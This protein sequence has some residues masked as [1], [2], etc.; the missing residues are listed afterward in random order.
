MTQTLNAQQAAA[1]LRR[2]ASAI[3]TV[4]LHRGG[5]MWP[6]GRTY[7]E[8]A[9]LSVDGALLAA[10]AAPHLLSACNYRDGDWSRVVDRRAVNAAD[11]ALAARSGVEPREVEA[12]LKNCRAATDVAA[13]LRGAAEDLERRQCSACGEDLHWSDDPDAS[14]YSLGWVNPSG[15]HRCLGQEWPLATHNA[16][17]PVLAAVRLETRR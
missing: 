10:L 8:G 7:P 16:V 14:G 9:P 13:L 5:G 3:E 1:L 11:T 4:G 12:Y 6:G 17:V 2:A 15:E